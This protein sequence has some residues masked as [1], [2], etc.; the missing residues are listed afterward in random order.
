MHDIY[1]DDLYIEADSQDGQLCAAFASMMHDTYAL[2]VT[3]TTPFAVNRAR[4]G[5]LKRSQDK[6]HKA[7]DGQLFDR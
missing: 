6:R 7:Q 4:R 5:A 2:A 3:Y 1:G